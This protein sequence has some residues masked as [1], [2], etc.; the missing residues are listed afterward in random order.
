MSQPLF[1]VE[2]YWSDV[3]A[4]ELHR[5]AGRLAAELDD[6]GLHCVESLVVAADGVAFVV[7]EADD[8]DDIDRIQQ[9]IA[10][11]GVEV[12]RVSVTDR[13]QHGEVAP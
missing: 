5:A 8:G 7:V 10:A 2:R 1:L 12:D 11:A 13:T 4:D 6:L 3:P 9:R